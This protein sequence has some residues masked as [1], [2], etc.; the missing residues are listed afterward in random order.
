MKFKK[1]D[2]I[3]VT[4][5]WSYLTG[6]IG[7]IHDVYYDQVARIY[8]YRIEIDNHHYKHDYFDENDIRLYCKCPEYFYE[9]K[10]G[11]N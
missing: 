4:C 5:Y 2:Q 6:S 7:K 11:K 8:F 1:N 10:Y 3:L 9:F